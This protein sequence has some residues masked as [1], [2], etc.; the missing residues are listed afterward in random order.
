MD[1]LLAV[2]K[3][4]VDSTSDQHRPQNPVGTAERTYVYD[5]VKFVFQPR[6]LMTWK[7]FT[8][9]TWGIMYVYQSGLDKQASVTVLD[10][11]YEGNVGHGTI[12]EI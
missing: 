4:W 12:T 1:A 5:N 7:M 3:G 9:V 8:T 10:D 6:P 11:R 2:E